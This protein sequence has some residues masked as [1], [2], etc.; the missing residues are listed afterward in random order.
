[1]FRVHIPFRLFSYRL[2]IALVEC[3]R[4]RRR[5]VLFVASSKRPLR[6]R[7]AALTGETRLAFATSTCVATVRSPSQ[8]V[9]VGNTLYLSGSIGLDPSTGQFAGDSV[10]EQARQVDA[11]AN[12][13][14][15]DWSRSL[16]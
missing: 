12:E 5:L 2:L 9:Q 16:S 13:R 15:D 4:R 14:P 10:Q 8:A 1:M 11:N 6:V 7:L 3:R